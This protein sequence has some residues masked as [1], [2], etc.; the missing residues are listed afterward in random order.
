MM[1]KKPRTLILF[2]VWTLCGILAGFTEAQSCPGMTDQELHDARIQTI[3]AEAARYYLN[4]SFAFTQASDEIYEEDSLYNVLGTGSFAPREVHVEYAGSTEPGPT[5]AYNPTTRL[6]FTPDLPTVTVD[7]DTYNFDQTIVVLTRTKLNLTTYDI[8]IGGIRNEQFMTFSP[9]SAKIKTQTATFAKDLVGLFG[10]LS[11]TLTPELACTLIVQACY[12]SGYWENTGYEDYDEC[13][14]ALEEAF[15]EP[16]ICPDPF[17]SITGICY[18]LHGTSAFEIPSV[19][20]AHVSAP[21]PA[22]QDRCLANGCGNCDDNASCEIGFDEET[23]TL[24]YYCQCH[25][26][27]TGN[28]ETCSAASCT[29]DYQCN[30]DFS[31]CDTETNLCACKDTFA[32]DQTQGACACLSDE[33][34]DWN[35]GVPRCLHPGRC[36]AREDCVNH[37]GHNWNNVGCE[38][39]SPSNYLSP[40]DFCLCNYGFD[41]LGFDVPCQCSS[42]KSVKWD[43]IRESNLCLEL[44]ECTQNWHCSSGESCVG[45]SNT[46]IGYCVSK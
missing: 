15:S 9:C 29:Q 43:P 28:G 11:A 31:V 12:N 25:D 32:W 42:P 18:V 23:L 22:C 17:S 5:N 39:T 14:A 45:A 40:G 7:G 46:T 34:L 24:S 44:H 41:N 10:D 13:F 35:N 38:Q 27:Y 19:H 36:L 21:S 33:F 30:G 26:G 4:D 16:S 3:V 2:A 6:F 8:Q 1:M 20:C 37:Y